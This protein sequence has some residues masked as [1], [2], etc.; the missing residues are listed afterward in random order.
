MRPFLSFPLFSFAYGVAGFGFP[1]FPYYESSLNG[2]PDPQIPLLTELPEAQDCSS[3]DILFLYDITSSM[4]DSFRSAKAVSGRLL[5]DIPEIY[6]DVRFAVATVGDFPSKNTPDDT[7]YFLVSSFRTDST[8]SFLSLE[9]LVLYGG[10]DVEESY[11]YALRSASNE[12]WRPEAKRFVVLFA[13]SRAR[14]FEQLQESV[15]HSNFT[16]FALISDASYLFYWE[17][18]T[19]HTF[20]LPSTDEDYKAILQ[21]IEKECHVDYASL[22]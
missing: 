18:V 19:P 20:P 17:Q 16:L 22:P 10:G 7:P 15:Q 1:P 6:Q 12:D 8:V 11:P 2:F 9:S 21:A 3:L 5:E 14:N 4:G 13:D